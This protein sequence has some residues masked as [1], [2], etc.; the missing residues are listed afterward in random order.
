MPP[1][2][3]VADD[4][5]DVLSALRLALSREDLDVVTVSSPDGALAAVTGEQFDAVLIDLN[6][7]RDTTSGTEGIELLNRLRLAD[8]DVPVIVMTAW[9]TVG[10]AVEAMR[11]GAR[12]FLEKPWDNTRLLSI[13]RNQLALG[14]ALRRSRL[15]SSMPSVPEVVSRV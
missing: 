11:A 5:Q 6:Y 15:S 8:P 14:R 13:I 9:A 4:Q 7:T 3:L 1:R 2:L 12:D 10:I